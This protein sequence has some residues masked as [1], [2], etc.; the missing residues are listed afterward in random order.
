MSNVTTVYNDGAG[1]T[2]TTTDEKI[3][4]YNQ[5]NRHYHSVTKAPYRDNAIQHL[6]PSQ[7]LIDD[8]Q[9]RGHEYP[10]QHLL[11]T[12]IYLTLKIKT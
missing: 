12:F 9:Y 7:M 6:P 8:T 11:Q 5:Y 10:I 1:L 3:P 4:L 2:T